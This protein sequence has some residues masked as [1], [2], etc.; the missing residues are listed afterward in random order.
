MIMKWYDDEDIHSMI[1]STPGDGLSPACR[2]W[3]MAG[4]HDSIERQVIPHERRHLSGSAWSFY[5]NGWMEGQA[6]LWRLGH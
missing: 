4:L 6:R 2:E 3:W 5:L 1:D